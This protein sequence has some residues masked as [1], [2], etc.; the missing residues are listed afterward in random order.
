MAQTPTQ[1]P[2]KPVWFWDMGVRL[3]YPEPWAAPQFLTGQ[4]FLA[5]VAD[6]AVHAAKQPFLAL[7]IIDPYREFGLTK[8]VTLEAVAQVVALTNG[9]QTTITNSKPGSFA[10]LEAWTVEIEAEIQISDTERL[11]ILGVV[12]AF[13]LPD[14]R[15]GVYLANAP[16]EQWGDF[17]IVHSAILESAGLLLPADY[18]DLTF[19]GQTATFPQGG[20]QFPIPVGWGEQVEPGVDAQTYFAQGETPYADSGLINGAQLQVLAL[21]FPAGGRLRDALVAF[22]QDPSIAMNDRTVG[23]ATLPA[24]EAFSVN[25]LN[26]QTYTFVAFLSQDGKVMNIFRWT[27]PGMLITRTRVSFDVI[28]SQVTLI[29]TTPTTPA[30]PAP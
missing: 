14:G 11:A 3:N 25:P 30:T 10:G 5:P 8:D 27:T 16:R 18:P 29:P 2:T 4:L 15:H 13:L 17:F 7:R 20:V 26:W 22:L 1:T 12:I 28:L 24:V 19:A 9:V 21:P 23:A 6:P